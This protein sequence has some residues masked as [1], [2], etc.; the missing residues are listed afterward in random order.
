MM[1]HKAILF[2]DLGIAEQV[3]TAPHPADVKKLGQRV[4]NFNDQKWNAN[5]SEIV[6]RGNFLKFTQ[7]PELAAF[8]LSTGDKILVEA[9]PFDRIW[10][11][12]YTEENAM[13]NKDNWG[14]NL[15]G[16]ALME[17]RKQLQGKGD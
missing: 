3:L 8:L 9:S 11:I 5:R 17:V 14:L 16:D 12:G 1:Y 10:G 15:L 2:D 4:Q 6:R 7:N 13:A